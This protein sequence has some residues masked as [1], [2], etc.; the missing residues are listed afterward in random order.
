MTHDKDF[1]NHCFYH[2][3]YNY[4]MVYNPKDEV[5]RNFIGDWK[6]GGFRTALNNKLL[7]WV[8]NFIGVTGFRVTYRD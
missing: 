1:D 2:A 7:R 8:M 3:M 6:I 4:S 5:M